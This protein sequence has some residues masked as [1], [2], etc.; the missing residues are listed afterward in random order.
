MVQIVKAHPSLETLKSLDE[1]EQLATRTLDKESWAFN[2]AASGDLITKCLNTEAFNSILLRPRIFIDVS[3]C[4]LSTTIMGQPSGLPIFISPM[5]MARRFHPSGEA[6]VTQ[7]CCKFGVM[8]IISN[9]ASMTPEEIVENAAPDHAHGFQ[10]YVQMDRRES[11]AVL[12]RINKLKVIK[13]LVLTLDEPVPGKHELKGQHGG[14]AEIQDRFEPSPQL[15]PAV[16]S[17]SGPAYNL[18]WKD[19]LSWITQHTELP[20]VLKGIQTHEDAYIASQFPQVKSIILSNHAGRVLD[21]APPAVHTLLEIRKY[22]PEVF[23]IVEVLVDGGIRRG[24]DVVKALCLGAKGV[25]IGRSVF[26]GLGA[27]GVRGVERTIEILADEIKTCMQ[28]LGVRRVADLGLQHVNT[29]IIE[30][31]IYKSPSGLEGVKVLV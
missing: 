28:L 5:A 23:D 16:P 9:N 14:K 29:S 18:T 20:I 12:A 19:T 27:G 24:T 10:L 7:A 25:G 31:Q 13:C 1:I 8:H 4:D 26:W 11:E 2:F 15:T 17:I 6:G 30:Q 21:T 3:R 22:C